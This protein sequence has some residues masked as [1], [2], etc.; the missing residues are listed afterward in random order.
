MEQFLFEELISIGFNI[1]RL[2]I[3]ISKEKTKFQLIDEI[4][5]EISSGESME[6]IK[7]KLI[8]SK[9][10]EREFFNSLFSQFY[11]KYQDKIDINAY[12]QDDKTCLMQIIMNKNL[13]YVIFI[14]YKTNHKININ[15]Q[16]AL[17]WTAIH[18]AAILLD[19]EDILKLLLNH[20]EIDLFALTNNKQNLIHLAC[21]KNR[22]ENVRVIISYLLSLVLK[23]ED[24]KETIR[25]ILSRLFSSR[26]YLIST[27]FLKSVS[28][29]SFDVAVE[30]LKIRNQVL[31][32]YNIEIFSLNDQD[33]HMNT[34][35]HYSF[36]HMNESFTLE[37]IRLNSLPIKNYDRKFCYEMIDN[38][39]L[40]EKVLDLLRKNN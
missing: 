5:S 36:E 9:D 27:P 12:N 17:N 37:L 20:N 7:K 8:V 13:D 29:G 35:L 18:Q 4:S 33:I 39:H 28:S 10:M 34:A 26:D 30:L 38:D 31:N 25:I 14:I 24:E 22:L 23:A 16:G 40:K 11:N 15:K 3:E 21:S 19:T 32:D 6:E 1:D 2:S